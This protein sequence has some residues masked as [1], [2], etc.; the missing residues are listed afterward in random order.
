MAS[1]FF[2]DNE[3]RMEVD[4]QLINAEP[5][6][7]L[8]DLIKWMKEECKIMHGDDKELMHTLTKIMVNLKN[9]AK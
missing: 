9:Q 5:Y 2:V 1:R 8:P 4:I 7:S 6:A 3:E